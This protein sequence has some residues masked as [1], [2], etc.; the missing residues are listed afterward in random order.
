MRQGDKV[1]RRSFLALAFAAALCL[2]GA[3]G[4]AGTYGTPQNP[5][6]VSVN[7]PNFYFYPGPG[8]S[9][10]P[11]YNYQFP[12]PPVQSF[13]EPTCGV[14]R[15]S[16]QRNTSDFLTNVKGIK[17]LG[18]WQAGQSGDCNGDN[19]CI[20]GD[21]MSFFFHTDRCYNGGN[22][23][24][25]YT[26]MYDAHLIFYTEINANLGVQNGDQSFGIDLTQENGIWPFFVEYYSVSVWPNGDFHIQIDQQPL[27][28]PP[29]CGTLFT[30]DVTKPGF[31]PNMYGACGY[32]TAGIVRASN[33]S[34]TAQFGMSQIFI[35]Q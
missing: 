19:S 7:L 25:L 27:F 28:C 24:G 5:A 12:A 1:R 17:F 30:R 23:Y 8:G 20:Q 2:S 11:P 10:W 21:I 3:P 34:H 33:V 35:G 29:F 31:M 16:S 32:L 18:S 13:W 9:A 4:S 6:W 14:N 26:R 22:E 15:N